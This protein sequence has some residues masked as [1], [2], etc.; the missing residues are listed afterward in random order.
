VKES[1]RRLV[2]KKAVEETCSGDGSPPRL[3]IEAGMVLGLPSKRKEVA[4][5]APDLQ[6]FVGWG[7]VE[8]DGLPLLL[9]L[10]PPGGRAFGFS[11]RFARR[12]RLLSLGVRRLPTI[13]PL[14]GMEERKKK[15]EEG[16]KGKT[17]KTGT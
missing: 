3:E 14:L 6:M 17:D 13:P 2:G 4:Q 5:P 10:L 16:W 11:R 15:E 8:K 12:K 9:A 7:Q 1:R